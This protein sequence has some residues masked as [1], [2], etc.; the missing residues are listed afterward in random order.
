MDTYFLDSSALVKSYVAETGSEWVRALGAPGGRNVLIIARIAW[1][2]I[3]SAFAR[4][5]REGSVPPVV[6]T[7]AW[8]T[9]RHDVGTQY[10]VVE[11]D[12]QG[13]ESAAELV[14]RHPLR[15][16]DAVQLASALRVMEALDQASLS[17]LTFLSADKRLLRAVAEEG[18]LA[19]D[20]NT[21][22]APG[23]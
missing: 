2:E 19:D 11:S 1:A 3:R 9:F 10:H 18:L 7:R 14:A 16:Y 17:T 12:R 15:A 23:V 13:I 21:H 5:Q 20:P 6:V 8:N 22:A 4:R